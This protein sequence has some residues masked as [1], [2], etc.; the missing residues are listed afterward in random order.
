MRLFY[1][2]VIACL[3]TGCASAPYKPGSDYTGPV[4]TTLTHAEGTAGDVLK[5]GAKPQD[6]KVKSI[7]KDLGTAKVQLKGATAEIDRSHK[8]EAGA[9]AKIA[10]QW[11]RILMD[12][13]FFGVM[14]LIV[15]IP[16]ILK[17]LP[18]LAL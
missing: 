1:P 11:H 6:P 12:D 14:A 4:A 9:P 15:L 7:V 10:A 13:I 18:L 3:L 16:I 5:T 8:A 17:I 2:I